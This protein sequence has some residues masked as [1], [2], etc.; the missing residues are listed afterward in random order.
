MG[1]QME[2]QT[3]LLTAQ[4]T[5]TAD[6]TTE[7]TVDGDTEA[8][9]AWR[10][11]QW[12]AQHLADLKAQPMAPHRHHRGREASRRTVERSPAMYKHGA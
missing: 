2:Q 11:A 5:H 7:G 6:G 10:L 9:K 1:R 3:G 4:L 12:K 8:L